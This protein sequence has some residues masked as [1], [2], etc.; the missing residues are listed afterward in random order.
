VCRHHHRA[1]A[2]SAI[3]GAP[4]LREI[5]ATSARAD[6]A[7][8]FRISPT[9]SGLRRLEKE[10]CAD[11]IIARLLGQPSAARWAGTSLCPHGMHFDGASK[12]GHRDVPA[13]FRR[14]P[15]TWVWADDCF[16]TLTYWK[17]R[18]TIFTGA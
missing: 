14:G 4:N 17:Q 12:C 18:R 10:M 2:R 8:P 16:H 13:H 9:D 6:I 11:I 3:C 7:P 15:L 1:F 5:S